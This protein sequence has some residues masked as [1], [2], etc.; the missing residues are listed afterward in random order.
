M[1]RKYQPS[2]GLSGIP[3]LSRWIS[4]FAQPGLCF[5]QYQS[6]FNRGSI[7]A[8]IHITVVYRG[9]GGEGGEGGGLRLVDHGHGGSCAFTLR[10]MS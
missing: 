1:T 4:K 5:F 3:S 10:V 7:S 2:S 9:G 6:K 8:S